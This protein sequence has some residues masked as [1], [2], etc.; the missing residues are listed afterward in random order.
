MQPKIRQNHYFLQGVFLYGSTNIS[1]YFVDVLLMMVIDFIDDGLCSR[2][3]IYIGREVKRGVEGEG[4]FFLPHTQA[5]F[6]FK[7]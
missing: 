3:F 2:C 5:E 7:L 6:I 1:K 4:V